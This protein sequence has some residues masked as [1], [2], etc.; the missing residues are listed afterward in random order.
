M[1][2]MIKRKKE[3]RRRRR[4]PGTSVSFGYFCL[5]GEAD[6]LARLAVMLTT[7][8]T[9]HPVIHPHR[10]QYECPHLT[11]PFSCSL[12]PFA[13]KHTHMLDA[14]IH[15]LC[16]YKDSYCLFTWASLDAYK[17]FINN[18]PYIYFPLSPVTHFLVSII[19]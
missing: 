1:M 11:S 6:K 2:K 16:L 9:S 5:L 14:R 13:H 18:S 3:K 7:Q 12:L 4:K 17:V 15:T 8:H 19:M 10:A